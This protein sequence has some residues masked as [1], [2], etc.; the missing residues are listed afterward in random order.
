[1]HF[2]D[3]NV[4]YPNAHDVPWGTGKGNPKGVLEELKR[5]GYQG[6]MSIEYESGTVEELDHNLPLCI[7]FFDKTLNELAK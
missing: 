3:L 2:K 4:L 7:A 1:M 5:Q 6:Y